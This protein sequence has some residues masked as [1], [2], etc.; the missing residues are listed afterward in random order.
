M[1]NGIPPRAQHEGRSVGVRLAIRHRQESTVPPPRHEQLERVLDGYFDVRTAVIVA[2]VQ[3][4]LT[5][6]ELEDP[7]AT[8]SLFDDLVEAVERRYGRD[9]PGWAASTEAFL[10]AEW[11]QQLEKNR[12]FY[13]S[14]E[15]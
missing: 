13:R 3:S 2:R 9:D 10:R 14:F 7:E 4:L 1:S 15:E 11:D 8:E 6:D 5:L 12:E